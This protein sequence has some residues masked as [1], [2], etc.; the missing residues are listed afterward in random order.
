M[1]GISWSLRPLNG[2]Y[3][4][5]VDVK[6]SDWPGRGPRSLG[7]VQNISRMTLMRWLWTSLIWIKSSSYLRFLVIRNHSSYVTCVLNA[8]AVIFGACEGFYKY[9]SRSGF[10]IFNYFAKSYVFLCD[11]GCIRAWFIMS[12]HGFQCGICQAYLVLT[13]DLIGCLVVFV[14]QSIRIYRCWFIVV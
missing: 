5:G 6:G 1:K 8:F 11:T 10:N 2:W 12:W 14:S 3:D 4:Q 7:E 13:W 9:T